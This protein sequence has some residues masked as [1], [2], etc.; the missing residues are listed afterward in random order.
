MH[1]PLFLQAAGTILV[2]VALS[3]ISIPLGV[4]FAG[5]ALIVFGI[6]AERT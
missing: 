6:A 4:G 3:L 5:T 1:I 2:I